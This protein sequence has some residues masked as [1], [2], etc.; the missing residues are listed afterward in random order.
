MNNRINDDPLLNPYTQTDTYTRWLCSICTS[1]ILLIISFSRLGVSS[2]GT[3]GF[4]AMNLKSLFTIS[5]FRGGSSAALLATSVLANT[6]QL[7]LSGLYFMYNALYTSMATANEWSR[8]ASTRKALRVT[9]PI[10]PHQ[11]GTYWLQLPW[12]FSLPLL[13]ASSVMHWLVSQSI[14]LVN[15]KIN[16]P[17]NQP[18]TETTLQNHPEFSTASTDGTITACGYSNFA[19]LCTIG[20]GI[21]MVATLTVTSALKL[22]PGIPLAGNCSWAISAACHPPAGDR[23]VALKPVQWGAVSHGSEGDGPGHCCFT[24][25]EVERPELGR[26]YAGSR[27]KPGQEARGG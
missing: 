1:G 24:S 5:S 11:R 21:L 9:S 10:G 8:Y 7:L 12:K 14:F 15:L 6:P 22:Q 18:L 27:L 16:L 13:I 4:G 23:E 25:L 26:L 17:T 3:L 19:I 2:L 20:V